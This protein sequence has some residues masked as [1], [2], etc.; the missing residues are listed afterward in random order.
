MGPGR[1]KYTQMAKK[2]VFFS[3]FVFLIG[4]ESRGG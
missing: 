1:T 2:D 4:P 3:N